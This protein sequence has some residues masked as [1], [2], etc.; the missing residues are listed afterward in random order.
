[1]ALGWEEKN[2]KF[3]M[4]EIVVRPPGDRVRSS[5]CPNQAGG[6]RQ[7]SG[8]EHSWMY[9]WLM[10]QKKT[11]YLC[12]ST[13]FFLKDV[14]LW[15]SKQKWNLNT[16]MSLEGKPKLDS[17]EYFVVVVI[18]GNLPYYFLGG[19]MLRKNGLKMQYTRIIP[20][21]KINLIWKGQDFPDTNQHFI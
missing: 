12:M 7:R 16:Y 13:I 20:S 1:M 6:D 4:E 5:A 19:G 2:H 11:A 17:N 21:S 9:L 3:Y 8:T 18:R 14:H 15:N 10:I